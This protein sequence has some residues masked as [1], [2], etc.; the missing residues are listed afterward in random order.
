MR[1]CIGCGER[2]TQGAMLRLWA[3]AH[4]ELQV[5]EH[6]CPPGRTGYLH[7]RVP[8]WQRFAARKGKVRSLGRNVDREARAALVEKLLAS[9]SSVMMG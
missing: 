7:R 8:C 2:D 6:R 1:T 5:L 9:E 3:G 4:G